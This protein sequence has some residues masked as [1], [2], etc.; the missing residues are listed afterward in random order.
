MSFS[1][2]VDYIKVSPNKTAPRNHAIDTLT[3]H[4]VVGQCTAQ[5]IG[6][7]FASSARQASCNYGIGFDGKKIGVVDEEHRSWCSSNKDNDH[8]AITFEIASDTT[9]PFAIT[10]AAYQAMIDLMVDICK[11]Y[12]KKK[13]LWFGDKDKTLAYNPKADEMVITVHRWFA[14]KACPGDYLYNR[15]GEVAKLVTDILNK[16]EKE[17]TP[18]EPKAVADW[19]ASAW[20]KAHAKIGRDGK[21]IMDGT[22]PTDNITRQEVAVILDRLGLLEP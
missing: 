2:L 19:A 17:E 5:R 13:V 20:E 3:P 18:M 7:I 10:D 9:T 15:L 11:R 12:G 4:V 16:P 8:R 1:P 21:P 22:R 6:E 14:R